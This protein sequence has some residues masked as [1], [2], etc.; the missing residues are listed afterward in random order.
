MSKKPHNLGKK[1]GVAHFFAAAQYSWAGMRFMTGEVPFRHEVS[2][3]L[4]LLVILFWQS[5]APFHILL[6]FILC[7][8]TIALEGFNSVIELIVD[9]VSPEYSD[10]AKNAKDVGSFAVCTLMIATGS[11]F[12]FAIYATF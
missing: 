11:S 9:R 2:A 5:A 12:A 6:T 8:V 4:V 3:T 7:L 1:T 10:F